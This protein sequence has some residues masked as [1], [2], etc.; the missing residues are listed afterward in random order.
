MIVAAIGPQTARDAASYGVRVDL[1]AKE[2]SAVS[3]I[4]AIVD[5]AKADKS[6]D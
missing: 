3:L 2:R 1:V 6:E 4:D 5:V